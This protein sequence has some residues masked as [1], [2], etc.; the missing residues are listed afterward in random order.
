MDKATLKVGDRVKA[1]HPARFG[2]VN[3]G[4]V[5]TVGRKWIHVDFGSMLGGVYKVGPDYVVGYDY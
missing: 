4:T 3:T 5:V 1:F 2:V